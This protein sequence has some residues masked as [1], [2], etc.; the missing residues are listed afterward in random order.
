MATTKGTVE[1]SRSNA[2]R[3]INLLPMMLSHQAVV[4]D[5]E[6]TGL[7]ARWHE[8]V[9][10]AAKSPYTQQ[11]VQTLIM[12][13]RPQDLLKKDSSGTCAY[14]INGIHPDD[15]VGSPTFEEVYPQIREFLEGKHWVCWNEQFDVNFFDVLCDKRGFERISRTGVSCAMK[16]LSPLAGQRGQRRGKIVSVQVSDNADDRV[17]WQKLSSLAKRMG[18]DTKQAHNAAADVDMTI[19]IMQWASDNI[20]TLPPPSTSF[21]PSRKT[22]TSVRRNVKRASIPPLSEADT[23]PVPRKSRGCFPWMLFAAIATA[24]MPLAIFG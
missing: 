16:L 14:D 7:N 5:I 4:F 10:F 19:Q 12:P 24:V 9:S 6:T 22:S 8:I 23:T 21:T 15:L 18:I 11:G 3:I 1:I 20:R 17:R 2:K 13:K